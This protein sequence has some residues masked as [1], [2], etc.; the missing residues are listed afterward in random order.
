MEGFLNRGWRYILPGCCEIVGFPRGATPAARASPP[1]WPRA[2]V[3]GR[4]NQWDWGS[5]K[6]RMKVICLFHEICRGGKSTPGAIIVSLFDRPFITRGTLNTTPH[7]EVRLKTASNSKVITPGGHHS[8]TTHTGMDSWSVPASR[9]LLLPITVGQ[10][11]LRPRPHLYL[12]LPRLEQGS[13][14]FLGNPAYRYCYYHSC[15]SSPEDR[16]HYRL[17]ARSSDNSAQRFKP[18][19]P[20]RQPL[21]LSQVARRFF[22]V[23]ATSGWTTT[24]NPSARST[25]RRPSERTEG[26]S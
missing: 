6:A 3:G 5:E 1:H 18:R 24:A 17:S 4:L 22:P 16:Y 21:R 7:L 15:A 23:I 11:S 26:W 25:R 19:G 10:S 13:N 8:S 12:L 20:N 2:G 9:Q 14:R